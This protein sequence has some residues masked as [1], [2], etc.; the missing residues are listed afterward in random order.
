MTTPTP[1]T[2][3]A[4]AFLDI[5][6]KGGRHDL[7]AVNPTL[8][9]KTLGK[10]E[11]ATFLP[12]DHD[13]L[14][15][16]IDAQ[17]GKRNVYA[18][19]NRGREEECIDWR[20]SKM[21]IS[22]IR[23][24]AVDL[25]PKKHDA[26]GAGDPGGEHFRQ[27]R[28][29]LLDKVRSMHKDPL[30]PP[31]VSVDSGGGYWLVWKLDPP[32]PATLEN[33]ALVEG[34]NRSLATRFGGDSSVQDV[35]R[36]MRLPGTINIPD[37]GKAKQGRT[38][39]L[40]TILVTESSGKTYTVDQLAAW[41]P[42]TPEH[43][44]PKDRPASAINMDV[45]D[46][47]TYGDLPA[48][49]R[50]KFEA[51][52]AKVPVVEKLWQGEPA[53]WQ[54]GESP[55]EFVF[56]LANVLRRPG[57]FSLTE[58]AQLVAV[59]EHRSE[60][61]ADDFE[62]Y[63]SRAW[64]RN[65]APL[66]G[67]GFDSVVLPARGAEKIEWN[68]PADL[69]SARFEAVDLP[70]GVVPEVIER[71]ARD[72]AKR[73][74][75]EA[76]ACAAAL[77]TAIGSLVPAGNQLQ[78]R[79]HDTDWT[80]KPILWTAI[81]GEPGSK[82][83]AIWEQAT[84]AVQSIESNWAK[85]YA[86]ER[87][88][89][90]RLNENKKRKTKSAKA[91]VTETDTFVLPP[92]DLSEDWPDVAC[93]PVRRRKVVQDATT[94]KLAEI[95][96]QN[97]DGLL[98]TSDELSGLFGGMDA[99]RTKGGKDRPFWLQAKEG[100]VSIIDRMSRDTQRV[101]NTAISVLG[102]IQP[103]LL[104][105]LSDD[106][107]RDGMLQ[108][109][110]PIIAKKIG[111]GEDLVPD[112]AGTDAVE[113]ITVA[114]VNAEQSGLFKFSP[115][116]DSELQ[117]MYAFQEMALAQPGATP[118]L[119]QWIDKTAGEFGRLSLVFHFIEWFASAVGLAGDNP[120]PL[121]SLATARRA[122]RFLTE[123]VYAH[124]LVFHQSVLGRSQHEGHTTWIAGFILAQGLSVVTLRDI[125]K[126]YAPFKPSETRAALAAVMQGLEADDWLSPCFERQKDGRPTRWHVNPAAHV[127]F[128]ARAVAERGARASVLASIG[129]EAL[130]R[131]LEQTDP[132]P[133]TAWRPASQLAAGTA[134]SSLA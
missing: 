97:S 14:R 12:N 9:E 67:E 84:K 47:N 56:A 112:R 120:P 123:F 39:E 24:L 130:R 21:N 5:L 33:I 32:I 127:A 86:V 38:P 118:T 99:Y 71:A 81:I 126:N 73:L 134:P 129:Q 108:R 22:V 122:R 20:L 74:G 7:F 3:L 36:V 68:E 58:F 53:P 16:W 60:T 37:A 119:R 29:R 13:D 101:E 11:A 107:A 91:A 128:A 6:D 70:A 124:A 89:F 49:L 62:R 2:N 132:E 78:M 77:V 10:T 90:D 43:A 1:N 51:Y 87:L 52:R 98:F 104:K 18:A 117:R 15:E 4:L 23:A 69:W 26:R 55:S 88:D 54:S 40:A 114:L 116:A 82:K 48:E 115:E 46:T 64:N 79:Q 113:Q 59:W 27:E 83:T 8:P 63:V 75:V 61:H 31:S 105:K 106:L 85:K 103:S 34:I 80:V 94:E 110:M 93:E 50:K 25:D 28:G 92:S 41:A 102:G 131:R 44:K 30:C 35:S 45:V 66:G 96:S 65:P 121:V 111:N 19:I 133:D 57:N 109:F 100:G 17:Q 42:P 125:Y 95:L 72:R 76:G